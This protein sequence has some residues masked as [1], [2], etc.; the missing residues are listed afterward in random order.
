MLVDNY[1]DYRVMHD[2]VRQVWEDWNQHPVPGKELVIRLRQL[3]EVLSTRGGEAPNRREF[4]KL[5]SSCVIPFQQ[6]VIRPDGK[7]SLC[8]NDSFGKMTLGDL[9]KQ[10]LREIWYGEAYMRIRE[11]LR[12]GRNE[13]PLCRACDAFYGDVPYPAER[14]N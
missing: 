7:V 3:N 5:V 9:T 10:S 1:N 2:N 13:I 11:K 8:S 14:P 6:M 4:P 12:N